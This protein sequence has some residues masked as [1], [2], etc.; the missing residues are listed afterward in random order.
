MKL[1][2]LKSC[3]KEAGRMLLLYNGETFQLSILLIMVAS[4]D[5]LLMGKLP[6][7]ELHSSRSITKCAGQL[8]TVWIYH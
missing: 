1:A 5:P 3:C 8:W 6:N 2:E 4:R 7:E